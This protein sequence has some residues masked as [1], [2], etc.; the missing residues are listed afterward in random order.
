MKKKNE[1]G[2]SEQIRR[3]KRYERIYD[4]AA[5]ALK[6]YD[7]DLKRIKEMGSEINELASYYESDLWKKD[8]SDDEAGL[9]P[10]DLKRGVLSEDGIYDLLDD[11]KKATDNLK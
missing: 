2:L 8:F 10:D 1:N 3:I 7:A 4:K 5:A 9:I 11:Y 6:R